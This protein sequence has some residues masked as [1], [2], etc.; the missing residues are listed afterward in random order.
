MSCTPVGIQLGPEV[1]DLGVFS[2]TL[3]PG[4]LVLGPK[5]ALQALKDSSI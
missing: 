5:E 1:G 3:V 2:I 4:P